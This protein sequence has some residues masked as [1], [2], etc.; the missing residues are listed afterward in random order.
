MS[1]HILPWGLTTLNTVAKMVEPVEIPFLGLFMWPQGK[2]HLLK[3][4]GHFWGD[5]CP[6]P[7]GQWTYPVFAHRDT[8]GAT[9]AT[10]GS[11]SWDAGCRY[12]YCSILLMVCCHTFVHVVQQ[13]TAQSC[14]LLIVVLI[15]RSKDE[16]V[17][18]RHTRSCVW[19]HV[20]GSLQLVH[21]WHHNARKGSSCSLVISDHCC[22]CILS[23]C[24][25]V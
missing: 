2:N 11:C 7:F 23:L 4:R 13:C 20:T 3:G 5:M 21:S 24:V 16:T 6:T 8:S 25:S 18:V 22:L 1:E 19:F 14:F 10:H 9:N 15:S 17:F 12:Q